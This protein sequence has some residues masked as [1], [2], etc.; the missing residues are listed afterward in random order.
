MEA[1]PSLFSTAAADLLKD[2]A[3]GRKSMFVKNILGGAST[4]TAEDVNKSI[5]EMET[6]SGQKGPRNLLRVVFDAVS[7]YD[8]VLNTLG[9]TSSPFSMIEAN[10]EVD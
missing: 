2:P 8:A 3:T 10:I 5:I 1:T 7:N 4:V 6:N 9:I